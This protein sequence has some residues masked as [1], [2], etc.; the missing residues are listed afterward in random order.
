[1]QERIKFR[2]SGCIRFGIQFFKLL[3]NEKSFGKSFP[4]PF[5]AKCFDRNLKYFF[6]GL[7]IGLY[8]I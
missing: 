2:L 5:S 7:L 3:K 4:F 6:E 1:M 8:S